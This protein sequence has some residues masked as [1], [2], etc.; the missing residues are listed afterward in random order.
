[1]GACLSKGP[2]GAA[3]AAAADQSSCAQQKKPG[4]VSVRFERAGEFYG[5]CDGLGDVVDARLHRLTLPFLA[6]SLLQR[7]RLFLLWKGTK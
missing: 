7:P 1:M 3:A 6:Q 5:V 2:D 4:S